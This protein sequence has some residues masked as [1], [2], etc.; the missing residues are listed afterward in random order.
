MD[1]DQKFQTSKKLIFIGW[2]IMAAWDFLLQVFGHFNLVNYGPENIPFRVAIGYI[3]GGIP[4]WYGLWLGS[5]G[6]GIPLSIG[7]FLNLLFGYP[8][9]IPVSI[10]LLINV[11]IPNILYW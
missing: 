8:C 7:V 3:V 10:L 6:I 2:I 9:W 5:R 4:M 1:I 11:V